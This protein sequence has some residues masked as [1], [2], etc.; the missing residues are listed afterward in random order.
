MLNLQVVAAQ[1]VTCPVEVAHQVVKAVKEVPAII[2]RQLAN[3]QIVCI[4]AMISTLFYINVITLKLKTSKA[5]PSSRTSRCGT[6]LVDTRSPSTIIQAL[7][8]V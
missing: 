3:L 1:A 2:P 6:I 7:L 4:S 5:S 8:K